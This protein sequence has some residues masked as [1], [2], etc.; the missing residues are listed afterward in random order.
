MWFDKLHRNIT[1]TSIDGAPRVRK[2]SIVPGMMGARDYQYANNS[3]WNLLRSVNERVFYRRVNGVLV[4]P[5][6]PTSLFIA[7]T[8]Q[9][10]TAAFCDN[11]RIMTPWSMM[12]MV[13]SY[14]GRKRTIYLNAYNDLLRKAI[15]EADAR[16]KT[17]GKAEGYDMSEKEWNLLVMRCIQPR[18]PRYCLALGVFLKSIEKLCYDNIDKI[19]NDLKHTPKTKTVCKGVNVKQLASIL[20]LKF[21]AFIDPWIIGLDA[22]RFDQCISQGVLDF[23]HLLYLAYYTGCDADELRYLLNMQLKNKGFARTSDGSF[24]YV[25]LGCRMSGDI[26]TSLGNCLI[27]CALI[28]C[29]CKSMG[30]KKFSVIDNGDDC[31]LIV[32]KYDQHL[33]TKEI[34]SEWFAEC[35]FV[36][37]VEEPVTE[38][39]RIDFCQMRPVCVENE[40]LMTRNPYTQ[41]TKDAMCPKP[42]ETIENAIVW[43]KSVGECGLSIAGGVPVQQSYYNC[44]IRNGNRLT[45]EANTAKLR[46][47]QADPMQMRTGLYMVIKGMHRKSQPV[48][49]CTRVSFYLTWGM[50]PDVQ[51]YLENYYDNLVINWK[52]K[53]LTGFSTKDFEL[54][55]IPRYLGYKLGYNV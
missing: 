45:K 41:V 38:F 11:A 23:E 3:F 12:R 53:N 7:N 42:F 13:N 46:K 48:T 30:I 44:L 43:I 47:Q 28:Y 37:K 40:W 54:P 4:A 31:L 50:T 55:K 34:I 21:S 39:N 27:M 10:F 26:N 33:V 32:E 51:R 29:F 20:H 16:L 9:A 18:S 22:S 5:Y 24:K 17:F 36:M 15:C 1:I 52:G 2:V 8:L 49:D 6:R 25:V 14:T 35:G 19:F